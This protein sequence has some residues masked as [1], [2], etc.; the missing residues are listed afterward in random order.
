MEEIVYNEVN[1]LFDTAKKDKA[2][3]LTC[4]CAQCRLD[5]ICYVLNKIPPRY[6]KSGR[7]LAYSQIEE[8]IEKSQLSADINKL[9][10]E[11]MKQVLAKQRPHS[12]LDQDFPDSPVFNFP[13]IIGRILNGLTFEPVKNIDVF[14]LLDSK[15]AESINASW[16]N[17]YRISSHTPGTFTFWVK[18]LGTKKEDIKKVFPFEI[19]ILA[20]GY[21]PIHYYFELGITSESVI[22]TAYSAEHAFML[23]DLHLFPTEDDLESMQG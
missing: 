4:S 9:G 7:G 23:P 5:T 15:N 2:P 8:S 14:L 10:L 21:D 11:G 16:D 3:W 6:I 1:S 13:T 18:P 22:R 12:E 17:P 19:K 20:E